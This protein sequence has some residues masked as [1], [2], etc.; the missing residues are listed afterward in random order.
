MGSGMIMWVCNNV[1]MWVAYG[2]E[3]IVC[4]YETGKIE[5]KIVVVLLRHERRRRGCDHGMSGMRECGL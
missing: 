1:L 3:A 2:I 5:G 4:A